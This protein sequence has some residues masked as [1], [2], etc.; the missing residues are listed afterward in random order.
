MKGIMTS[1]LIEL[2]TE[3]PINESRL[4]AH[5]ELINQVYW[6]AEEGIWLKDQETPLYR[7]NSDEVESLWRSG[8]LLFAQLN[9]VVVGSVKVEQ[10]SPIHAEFGMLIASESQRGRGLGRALVEAAES[11][12][13]LNGCS[14]MQ[15]E[16]LNPTRWR[17]PIKSFLHDW[18]L[19][20]GYIPVRTEPFEADYPELAS[21]LATPCDFTIYE[22]ALVVC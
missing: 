12:A 11:W 18:Y 3:V 16:L 15:L 10:C 4:F 2:S 21:R 6:E 20:L 7:T 9:G 1:F 22:K 8:H 19:R 14:L 5:V 17:H 13:V